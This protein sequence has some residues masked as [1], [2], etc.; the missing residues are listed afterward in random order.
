MAIVRFHVSCAASYDAELDVPDEILADESALVEYLNDHKD[1][2]PAVDLEWLDDQEVISDDIYE[3]DS[4]IEDWTKLVDIVMSKYQ[5]DSV[6]LS[7]TF[8]DSIQ[9]NMLKWEFLSAWEELQKQCNGDEVVR[10]DVS[11][12]ILEPLMPDDWGYEC[13]RGNA[14]DILLAINEGRYHNGPIFARKSEGEL[15]DLVYGKF[16]PGFLSSFLNKQDD[17]EL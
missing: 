2:C 7:E 11:G 14:K 1:E 5:N 17:R 6:E 12:K 9:V 4:A 8:L 3:V 15:L 13:V 16:E 10:V